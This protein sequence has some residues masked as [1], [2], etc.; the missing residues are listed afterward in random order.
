MGK[1]SSTILMLDKQLRVLQSEREQL[2][3][4]NEGLRREQHKLENELEEARVALKRS[5][6]A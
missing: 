6:E 1:T 2:E 3:A 4:S 5:E